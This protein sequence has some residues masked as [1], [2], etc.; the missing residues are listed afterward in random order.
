MKKLSKKKKNKREKKMG[1]VDEWSEMNLK[2][3]KK[4]KMKFMGKEK[5][6]SEREWFWEEMSNNGEEMRED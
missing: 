4:K 2:K 6:L 3:K 5:R 1:V